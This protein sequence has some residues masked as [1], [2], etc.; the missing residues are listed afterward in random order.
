[1]DIGSYKTILLSD[2]LKSADV[3]VLTNDGDLRGQSL[4]YGQG[5]ILFPLLSEECIHI[6]C[7]CLKSLGCNICCV[8]LELLVLCN[9][10]SLSVYFYNNCLFMIIGQSGNYNTFCCDTASLLSCACKAFLSQEI[11][12]LVHITVGSCKSLL[13]IHH[14]C[15]GYFS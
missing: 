3:H 4:F 6:C 1:M 15:S 7:G 2:L 11:N 14:A 9:E 13:A 8:G 10:I 5:R 12:C